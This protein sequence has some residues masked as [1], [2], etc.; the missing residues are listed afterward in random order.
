MFLLL[1]FI[2]V[3]LWL[4]RLLNGWLLL[5]LIIRYILN[6]SQIIIRFLLNFLIELFIRNYHAILNMMMLI[7]TILL[8]FFDWFLLF[9]LLFTLLYKIFIWLLFNIFVLILLNFLFNLFR[10]LLL[11]FIF[12]TF[13]LIY[14]LFWF[15]LN[16]LN[17][18]NIHNSLFIFNLLV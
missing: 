8:N 7:N 6:W 14:W 1:R 12:L 9:D 2:L 10:W 3:L 17:R 5:L 16:L 4:F 18:T 11:N 15:I 13:D